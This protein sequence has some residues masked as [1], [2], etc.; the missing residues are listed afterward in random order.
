[1]LALTAVLV[2]GAGGGLGKAVVR[3]ALAR[4]LNVS[5]LVRDRAKFLASAGALGPRLAAT[6]EGSGADAAAV[7]AAVKAARSSI[8]IGCLG[9]DEAFARGTAEG[10][11]SAGASKLVAVAGATNLMDED[12]V[13]P[14]WKA[15]A[16][17]WPPA[18][19]AFHAHGA[20]IERYRAVHAATPSLNFVVFCPP[21]MAERGAASSPPLAIRINR[22]GADFISYED[23]A[24][25]MAEAATRSDFDNQLITGAAPGRAEL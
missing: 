25:I 21:M 3:E 9:G 5:V 19:R 23:A 15:W 13:T 8:V 24:I 4:G 20:A 6:Y 18:E 2:V 10:A 22:P 16:A 14:L 12:G 11:A 7:E 1:M 17:K